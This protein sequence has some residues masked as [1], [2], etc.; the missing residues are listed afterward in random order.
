MNSICYEPT[1]KSNTKKKWKRDDLVSKVIDFEQAKQSQS[2]RQW[3]E[4]H[5]VPRSTLQHWIN[6]KKSIDASPALIS[7]FESPDGIAFLHRMV[8]AAHLE[9]TKHGVA[10]IHNISNFLGMCGVSPFIA[11]SYSTQCRASTKMDDEIIEFEKPQRERLS[12]QMPKKKISL[13]E[14][15]TFH[16]EICLVAMEPVSNYLLVEKYV[17]NREGETWNDA[18]AEAVCGLPVEVIQVSSDEG[19]GLINHTIKGLKAHHSSDCFHVSHEIGKGTSGALASEVRRAEKAH[20]LAVKKTQKE[21]HR[22]DAYDNQPKR[23]CGPRP[24]FEKNIATV[25]E[26][27]QQAEANLKK[28]RDNQETVRTAKAEIGKV[29]R[30][31]DPETGMKQEAKKVSELLESCFDRINEAT[32]DISDR[33]KKRVKKAYGVVSNMV[34]TIAFFFGMIDLYMDNMGLSKQEKRL[35]HHYLIPGF[36][37]CQVAQRE[38]DVDRKA[39]ISEKSQELLSIVNNRNGPFADYCETDIARLKKAAKE[40][41]QIFQRSSSCVEGRNAQLSLRHHGIHRL[42]DRHLKAQTVVH[43]YYVKRPDGT[44]PAERFFESKHEDLFEW[45]LERMDY[46]STPR[47]RMAAAS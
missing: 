9:F 8:T 18:V 47:R 6:R 31:Y 1:P 33:C 27:Q 16:P 15:E 13:C 4:E 23:P 32:R 22:K 29:Y 11:S 37:L 40:C 7:F 3:A 5:G 30:P 14:D 39:I 44:T 42:S 2:Q 46:P 45:L 28:A 10:S 19:R 17:E 21:I 25:A 36:Y 20:E 12:A 24:N 35:I 38:R 41:A 34:A 43:N 26:E